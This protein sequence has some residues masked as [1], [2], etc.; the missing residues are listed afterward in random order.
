MPPEWDEMVYIA[1]EIERDS[2]KFSLQ[3]VTLNDVL[4]G[5]ISRGVIHTWSES[6][7]ARYQRWKIC[8]CH[9]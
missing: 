1:D 8:Y 3:E 5:V 2:R 4:F 7:C 6:D 9:I